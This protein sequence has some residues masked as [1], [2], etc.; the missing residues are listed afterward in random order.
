MLPAALAAL[1]RAGGAARGRVAGCRGAGS[2]STARSARGGRLSSST[3]R[4]A[5]GGPQVAIRARM[6]TPK[7]FHGR[8]KLRAVS[9]SCAV[10]GL[11]DRGRETR[12]VPGP[13]RRRDQQL[14]DRLVDRHLLAQAEERLGLPGH[15]PEPEARSRRRG[16]R[17]GRS[18]RRPRASPAA[19]PGRRKGRRAPSGAARPVRRR[20]GAVAAE[21]APLDGWLRGHLLRVS[22]RVLDHST[23]IRC[24]CRP[25][26]ALPSDDGQ[27][28]LPI[29]SPVL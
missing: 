21:P 20:R 23:H 8:T 29:R 4:A 12:S 6:R 27:A 7:V 24:P 3:T 17:R 18:G 14:G 15:R 10:G 28:H 16:R 5:R 9:G 26:S 19:D 2:G 25:S 13:R 22:V 1:R 11:G